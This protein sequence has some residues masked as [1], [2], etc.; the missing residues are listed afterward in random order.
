MTTLGFRGETTGSGEKRAWT[1]GKDASYNPLVRGR[2]E[3]FGGRGRRRNDGIDTKGQTRDRGERS[4]WGGRRRRRCRCRPRGTTAATSCARDRSLD[5]ESRSCESRLELLN[6]PGR[7]VSP[8]PAPRQGHG[9]PDSSSRRR[10]H[11]TGSSGSLSARAGRAA[12][13]G[14]FRSEAFTRQFGEA[15]FVDEV[16]VGRKAEF[17]R[18]RSCEARRCRAGCVGESDRSW[19]RGRARRRRSR[20]RL[21]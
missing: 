7:R 18:V 17:A 13:G 5:A 21:K 14:S 2:R 9:A 16:R 8:A 20:R 11:R 15:L 19:S 4:S 3:R 6:N 10:R 1:R 12:R